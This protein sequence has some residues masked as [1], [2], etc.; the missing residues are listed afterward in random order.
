MNTTGIRSDNNIIFLVNL[1]FLFK[2]NPL[3]TLAN[4]TLSLLQ[5]TLHRC[6]WDN[7]FRSIIFHTT[8]PSVYSISCCDAFKKNT[9]IF[10]LLLKTYLWSSLK[11]RG[12]FRLKFYSW[13]I[14]EGQVSLVIHFNVYIHNSIY[15]SSFLRYQIHEI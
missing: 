1:L 9:S 4:N 12:H 13:K 10:V 5:L 15:T 11:L 14:N 6:G 8:I 7:E 3:E 2:Y